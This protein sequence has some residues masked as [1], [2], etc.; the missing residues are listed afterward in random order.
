MRQRALTGLAAFALCASATP[1]GETA[2]VADLGWMSGAW[3]SESANELIEELWL[4][5]HGEVMVGMSRTLR[6][7]RTASFEFLR[8]VKIEG[9]PTYVA[10]PNGGSPVHF[11]RTSGG[12]NHVRFENPAHDFP[13]RIEYRRTDAGLQAE[14]AGPGT[15]GRE[16]VIAFSY[17]RC[18]PR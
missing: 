13:Q 18:P 15:G 1:A 6:G 5:P 8:I 16:K 9:V 2:S 12:K 3:C 10:Q 4:P 7:E 11:V 14:I 17:T